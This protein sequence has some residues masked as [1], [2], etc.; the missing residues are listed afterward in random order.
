MGV[1]EYAFLGRP[2]TRGRLVSERLLT[3]ETDRFLHYGKVGTSD[4]SRKMSFRT[5]SDARV[6]VTALRIRA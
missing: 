5:C 4:C 2:K 3:E 6:R 1:D